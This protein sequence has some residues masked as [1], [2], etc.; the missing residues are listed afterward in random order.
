M[1]RA[2]RGLRPVSVP[3]ARDGPP[4]AM[5]EKFTVS[6][7]GHEDISHEQ[8]RLYMEKQRVVQYGIS[9]LYGGLTTLRRTIGTCGREQCLCKYL[10]KK[11]L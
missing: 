9:Y 11:W 1:L 8:R 5:G 7:H 2:D 4:G 3:G 6:Q 10:I